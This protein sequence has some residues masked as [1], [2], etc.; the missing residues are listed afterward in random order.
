MCI[1]ILPRQLASRA[2]GQ[3]RLESP[4]RNIV[5]LLRALGAQ[6]PQLGEA[7]LGSEGRPS[8]FLGVFVDGVQW[9]GEEEV[10]LGAA[11]SVQLIAAVAGG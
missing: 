10:E 1:V 5:A 6:H 4:E 9:D 2:G 3:V 11:S 7:I 8:P